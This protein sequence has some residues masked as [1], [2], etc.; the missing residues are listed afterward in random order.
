MSAEIT[1]VGGGPAGYVAAL[2]ASDHGASV[3]LIGGGDLGGTC[4]RRGCIPTKA[5]VASAKLISQINRGKQF[6]VQGE[7]AVSADWFAAQEHAQRIAG[8][9]AKGVE[10]LLDSRGIKVL[11]GHARFLSPD[12]LETAEGV[13]QAQPI[14]LCTGSRPMTPA[15]F[16]VDHD[17]IGTSDDVLQW[18]TLPKSVLIVGGGVIACEF[19]FVLATFGASVTLV[20][21]LDFPLPGAE[22][23]VRSTLLREMKKH[24]IR[25]I[26]GVTIEGLEQSG[27]G[28]DCY[29]EGRV[30]ATAERAVIAVGR[31][32]NSSTLA[33]EQAGLRLGSRGEIVVDQHQRTNV[34]GIYA[35]G[36]V[37]GGLMLAHNASFQARIAVNHILGRVPNTVAGQAIPSVTF[38][39]PEVASVGLTEDDALAH[40]GSKVRTGVFDLRA[41]GMAHALRELSGL[42][43][44]VIDGDTRRILGVHIVGAHAADMINEASLLVNRQCTVD[45]VL[46]TVHAHPTLSEAIVEAAEAAANGISSHQLVKQRKQE[47]IADV[48]R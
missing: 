44:V 27:T 11:S 1:I 30:I 32:P 4:L 16:A 3:T 26:G 9:N 41:L 23:L 38:T 36:D 25:F 35:A 2:H 20:E 22:P 37:T 13:L 46:N 19:A 8:V 34:S 48:H 18:Q 24:G 12:M 6:G 39:D 42:V 10:A 31:I 5:L 28:V 47:A 45:D 7:S 40:H 15:C 14:L 43:K 21:Q 29:A 17:R 33:V